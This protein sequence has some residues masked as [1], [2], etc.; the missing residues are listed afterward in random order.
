MSGNAPDEIRRGKKLD[1]LRAQHPAFLANRLEFSLGL[2]L[3][4]TELSDAY[5]DFLG[6][7]WQTQ[8]MRNLQTLIKFMGAQEDETNRVFHGVGL[9]NK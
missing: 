2:M 3:S 4:N 5:T 8:D 6:G 7:N 9:R 1:V